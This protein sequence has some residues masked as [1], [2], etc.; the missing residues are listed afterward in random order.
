MQA[1][2]THPLNA[3]WQKTTGKPFFV[4]SYVPP[5]KGGCLL[6]SMCVIHIISKPLKPCLRKKIST[7]TECDYEHGDAG[8]QKH[9]V[10]VCLFF[11]L[12]GN[13]SSGIKCKPVDPKA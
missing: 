8:F 2:R 13:H 10:M 7:G 4:G 1:L 12:V 11:A 3:K 5:M 9:R 6:V